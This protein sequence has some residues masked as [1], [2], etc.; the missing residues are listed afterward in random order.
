M[1]KR[2]FGTGFC[3]CG[4]WSGRDYY[5]DGN[6]KPNQNYTIAQV[7]NFLNGQGY[8]AWRQENNGRIDEKSLIEQLLKL[9]DALT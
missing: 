4:G 9:F 7:V 6:M 1:G 5:L 3:W 2:C 8:L